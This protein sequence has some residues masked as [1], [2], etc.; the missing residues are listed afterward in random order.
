V[1]RRTWSDTGN[2]EKR[3]GGVDFMYGEEGYLQ[4]DI[5]QQ[6]HGFP[7]TPPISMYQLSKQAVPTW[8]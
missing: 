2:G 5:D 6:D 7:P 8:R 1:E 4:R 3:N